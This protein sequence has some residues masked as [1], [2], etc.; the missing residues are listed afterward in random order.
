MPKQDGRSARLYC[1][2][3]RKA[4]LAAVIRRGPSNHVMLSKW[5][6]A[7]DHF[8]DGQWFKGRIYERRCDI[9]PDG[10]YII[11]FGGNQKPPYGTWTAISSVPW[12]TAHVLWSEG[13]TWGGG[14]LFALS[15]CVAINSASHNLKPTLGHMP[16]RWPKVISV[17]DYR[18]FD[19]P[20]HIEDIRMERDGWVL[21]QDKK[22]SL[23][24][25][26]WQDKSERY[27]FT[28]ER[29]EIW[30]KQ[31]K[32]GMV[33]RFIQAEA[34]ERDG[35]WHVCS[36]HLTFADGSELDLGDID[37]VDFDH[38][39]DVLY[40]FNGA[41]FRRGKNGVG[42]ARLVRDLNDLKFEA[43]IAP[44]DTRHQRRERD[45]ARPWHPLDGQD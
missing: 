45:K 11:Y 41:L 22:W 37:W 12:F 25:A 13:D 17:S 9:S 44:Y 43:R 1:L 30:R 34:G 26:W 28:T 7:K 31:S 14:G 23:N 5:D 35:R 42:D 19:R 38:N 2:I 33:L 32:A 40:A 18:N 20:M 10:E 29:P 6:L 21:E 24:D 15:K 4:R 3:A 16:H 36:G 27:R 39:G 8:E